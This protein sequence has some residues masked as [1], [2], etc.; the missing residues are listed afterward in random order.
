MGLRLHQY[1]SSLNAFFSVVLPSPAMNS[2]LST[3][4]LTVSATV[5]LPLL[6]AAPA[7]AV[8]VTVGFIDYDVTVFKGSYNSNS[9]LFQLLPTGKVPWWGSDTLA[10]NFAQQVYDQL[11]SGPTF[12][13]G[14]VFAY[15]LS[16]TDILGISQNLA[17]P[18]SQQD[19]TIADN[20]DV[21]YAIATPLNS[22]PA[23]VPA[24]LPVFGA[25]AALGWSR[26]L[27]KRITGS[28]V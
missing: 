13:Y 24:P 28:K 22:A 6:A 1:C 3:A 12:G 10:V 23:S 21:N 14:P 16:G 9:A 26:Q 11:G 18:S 20:A 17:D 7:S 25:A 15:E 8:T 27:R 2:R 4:L 19:E 5:A